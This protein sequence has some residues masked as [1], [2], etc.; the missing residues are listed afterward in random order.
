M[1]WFGRVG[2]VAVA[3]VLAAVP[4]AV[5]GRAAPVGD[6]VLNIGHRGASG[7]A[8]EHTIPAYDLAIELGADYLEQ[9]LQLT[10]D[11]VLVVLHDTTLDRTARG[12]AEDCTGPVG[13]KTLAQIKR[14]DVG[15]WFNE[16]NPE[17]GRPE[18]VGLAIPT[19]DEVFS[20]YR[21]RVNY[22]IETK[23]PEAADRMEE[24]LLALLAKHRLLGPARRWKV[25]I[26]SFSAASLEKMHG[27][28]PSL[29][30]V[31]LGFFPAPGPA[32]DAALDAVAAYAV[33]IGPPA[34]L[35]EPSLV[36]GAH[37]RCLDV[38]PWTVNDSTA[39]TMLVAAG[40]DGLFTNFPDRLDETLGANALR[41]KKAARR[42]ARAR[43]R[44]VRGK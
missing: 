1:P 6:V 4:A 31:Q 21:R 13:T 36:D 43:K 38:H 35:V 28:E 2:P 8:P 25:L 23:T 7:H 41:A 17:R 22:Y 15:S 33:G 27:L 19:L 40:V 44:C 34:G 9:D 18:F 39:M 26:Q 20:R 24:R 37:A 3:V 10:Q 5:P 12:P 14:C 29:P 30:L 32:F 16:A 11:G 42:A